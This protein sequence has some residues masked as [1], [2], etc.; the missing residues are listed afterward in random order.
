M[1]ISKTAKYGII[2]S[3]D[4]D[5]EIAIASNG[6]DIEI[7]VKGLARDFRKPFIEEER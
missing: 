4:E 6:K 3:I 2:K 1:E 7:R 5:H